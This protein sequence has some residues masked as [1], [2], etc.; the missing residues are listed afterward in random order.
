MATIQELLAN[1][2]TEL[3]KIQN[4]DNSTVI[5]SN[6][7]SS[8]HLKRLINN[9]FL[10][11]VIK[12]W[13]IISSPTVTQGDT[14]VWYASYWH[15]IKKYLT[16]RFE[17]NWCLSA[18]QSLS[19]YSGS[20]II[21]PQIIIRS[22]KA[23]NSKTDLIASTSIFALQA[24]IP[25]KISNNNQ[26]G[27]NLY[28]LEEAII[29]ASPAMYINDSLTM[30]TVL[31]SVTNV[32]DILK[33]LVD[34]GQT[35]RGGR[36]AGA[37]R[38]IGKGDFAD[39][40]ISTLKR[41]GYDI[42][43]ED[44]FKEIISISPHKSPYAIRIQLMWQDMRE[45][46]IS[47]F[48]RKKSKLSPKEFLQ[49]MEAQYKLDAYHSLSIEGYKVTDELIDKVNSGSW[50]PDTEDANTK[51]ALAARGY[52]QAFQEVKNSVSDILIKKEDTAQV[53]KRDLQ[54]WYSEL[55]MPCIQAGIIKPS[56]IIGYRSN[57]V[58]IRNSMH[59][60]LNPD[61]LRDAMESLFKLIAEEDDA[62]VRAV[63]G[64]FIFTF[65]HPYMDGNGRTG[66]FL[67]NVMMASG[68]Y[69]WLIIPVNRRNE[70]MTALEKA[71]VERNILPFVA[72]LNSIE[73]L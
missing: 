53:V 71:S 72:F 2:L 43:E 42:R 65:I 29:A 58:Y 17:N 5:K 1:S 6:E 35:V 11:P 28:P 15:F 27:L 32:D 50:K 45:V 36:V 39:E 13:Y 47:N 25:E 46:V 19:I 56:D 44:P 21:S 7:L 9:G 3:Q 12:G 16:D 38:N 26:Y 52:W 8:T 54:K 63:L 30:R 61:A 60:P 67:M 14:T 31:A 70:Y 59:T 68:G 57:Q 23:T 62:R 41:I 37:F 66:R 34:T 10:M 73:D 55:F 33:I 64:H 22:P 40:I 20:T 24:N 4:R 51:N 48:N 69:D 49:N 18:E